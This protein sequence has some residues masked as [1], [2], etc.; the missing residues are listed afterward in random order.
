MVPVRQAIEERR[1]VGGNGV[2][3][4]AEGG[5]ALDKRLA[6]IFLAAWGSHTTL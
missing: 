4:H 1:H 6:L 3:R 2:V 5:H